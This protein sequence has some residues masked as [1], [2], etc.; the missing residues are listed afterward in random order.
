MAG[1][2]VGFECI[3]DRFGRGEVAEF[4]GAIDAHQ[5]G[6]GCGTVV[7]TIRL[8]VLP[9]DHGRADLTLREVVLERYVVIIEE[10]EEVFRVL[11]KTLGQPSRITVHIVLGGKIGK[12]LV[13]SADAVAILV[14]R[15]I[16]LL[17]QTNPFAQES[18]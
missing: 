4:Q 7:R 1:G 11:A 14:G 3:G 2:P 5:H 16:I 18:S 10:R 13:Q 6:L 8:T 17:A 15:K 12:P 9:Q